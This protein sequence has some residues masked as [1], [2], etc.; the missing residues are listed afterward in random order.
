MPFSDDGAQYMIRAH[1]IFFK[2]GKKICKINSGRYFPQVIFHGMGV[3]SDGRLGAHGILSFC[4][5]TH[6]VVLAGTKVNDS[7]ARGQ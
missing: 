6:T 2:N 1:C 5:A 4:M 3:G 7:R